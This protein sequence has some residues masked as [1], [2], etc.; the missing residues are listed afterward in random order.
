MK[1]DDYLRKL[2]ELAEWEIPKVDDVNRTRKTP[3][4]QRRNPNKRFASEEERTE[5]IDEITPD[6][7]QNGRNLTMMPRIVKLKSQPKIC[8]L[9][10]GQE[11]VNQRIERTLHD[12]PQPHWRTKCTNC[13]H[14]LHP[15]GKGLIKGVNQYHTYFAKKNP[16]KS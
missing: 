15:S 6:F 16:K 14:Y 12:W 7:V 10:C 3:I 1:P 8:E 5:Y 9:G 11:V 13:Q 4:E 2:S